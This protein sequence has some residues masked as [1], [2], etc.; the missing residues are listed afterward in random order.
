MI[1]LIITDM[2]GT[3][4]NSKGDFD[5]L[6]FKQTND[7]MKE[8]GVFFAPCTGKQCERV[9]ELFEEDAADLWILGDS[10]TRIKHNGQ[11]VYESLI[12]NA[13]GL[14]AIEALEEISLEHTI[15]ACT[16][17]GAVVK[18]DI[19]ETELHYVKGSYAEVIEVEDFQ[20]IS[21][22]FLKITLHDP[23]GQCVPTKEKMS[24]FEDRL[25]IVASEDTWIDI[26]D[27]DVH[28]GTTI[29]KLQSILN[30][31]PAETMVFGDGRNDVELMAS[32]EYSFAVRNAC[33]EILDAANFVTKS[34]EE[35]GV[36][37]AINQ[38]L[39]LQ[40]PY[41]LSDL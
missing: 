35:S 22:D 9:E 10:A 33:Q 7:V 1:K 36:L 28:K 39:N 2:D 5:R 32:G 21:D 30:V 25:Y 26:A 29:K 17:N 3:F 16:Q 6:L 31:S 41:V 34:N 15:I 8:Q 40:Q 27:F 24:S 23:L 38:L 12:P 11:F 18:K 13:L 19:P 4:L 20:D 14:K 37:Y